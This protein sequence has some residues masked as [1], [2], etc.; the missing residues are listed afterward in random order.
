MAATMHNSVVKVEMNT[1]RKRQTTLCRH[2]DTFSR[3]GLSSRLRLFLQRKDDELYSPIKRISDASSN[4]GFISRLSSLDSATDQSKAIVK[5]QSLIRGYVA[6]KYYQSLMRDENTPLRTIRYFSRLLDPNDPSLLQQIKLNRLKDEFASDLKNIYRQ[7]QEVKSLKN[8]IVSSVKDKTAQ[9]DLLS[10][11]KKLTSKNKNKIKEEITMGRQVICEAIKNREKV[12]SYEHL[13]YCLQ[14]DPTYLTRLIGQL[15]GPQAT[16]TIVDRLLHSLYNYASTPREE[17]FFVKLMEATLREEVETRLD[18]IDDVMN[19]KSMILNVIVKFYTHQANYNGLVEALKPAIR[20]ILGF[21][22][23]LANLAVRTSDKNIKTSNLIERLTGIT[24]PDTPSI[25]DYLMYNTADKLVESIFSSV[26]RIPYGLRYLTKVLQKSLQTKFPE[27]TEDAVLRTVSQFLCQYFE[28]VIERPDLFGLIAADMDLKSVQRKNLV[29]VSK[30]IHQTMKLYAA[31]T[32]YEPK[33]YI[34]ICRTI[35]RFRKFCDNVLNVPEPQEKFSFNKFVE[36]IQVPVVKIPAE[37]IIYIHSLL[38]RYEN[39]VFCDSMDIAY[40]VFKDI[41][42][43]PHV[44][45]LLATDA[46]EFDKA[47]ERIK[48]CLHLSSKFP[49]LQDFNAAMENLM[50]ATKRMALDVIRLVPGE[51]LQGVL[52]TPISLAQEEQYK[53]LMG[54]APSTKSCFMKDYDFLMQFQSHKIS[55]NLNS[56]QNVCA[57]SGVRNHQ[58]FLNLIAR[59][60]K[61]KHKL[62]L[63][64]KS[65]TR[66]IQETLPLLWNMSDDLQNLEDLYTRYWGKC[67]VNILCHEP[68]PGGEIWKFEDD[69]GI[70]YSAKKLLRK[71]V[72]VDTRGEFRQLKDEVLCIKLAREFFD[73]SLGSKR[74]LFPAVDVL[75]LHHSSNP[76]L[77][78]F[79]YDVDV[80]MF[81]FLVTKLFG[82]QNNPLRS[83]L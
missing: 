44:N 39:V 19:G 61:E 15:S 53:A 5:L 6:R 27:E 35:P 24:I 28:P 51:T 65:E 1:L 3:E 56:L 72:I 12:D 30:I 45:D 79:Q 52:M 37:D 76:T 49:L 36:A 26:D 8:D 67:V 83:Y 46:A 62:S 74:V 50:V 48:I 55:A 32:N 73:V 18:A 82:K 66:T 33:R 31:R 25:D 22:K 71:G 11:Y 40:Q 2:L 60:I 10:R 43:V 54:G 69:E 29:Y 57:F 75:S 20:E 17:Y 78:L 16:T 14:T 63:E 13:F 41:G 23:N 38:S 34:Y 80:G 58:D 7:R 21:T 70:T 68:R 42:S 47:E 77:K 4:E 59:E 9:L 81:L 64:R